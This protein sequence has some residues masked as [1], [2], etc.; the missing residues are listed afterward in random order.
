MSDG[1]DDHD[2]SHDH[3]G[4]GHD[5]HDHSGDDHSHDHDHDHHHHDADDVAVA[6]VTVSSSRDLD[7]DPAGDAIETRLDDHTVA[8]RVVVPDDRAAIGAAIDEG[9]ASADAVV[10][11]G[12]TG[13]TPDDVTVDAARERF[14]M[15]L[16]GFGELFRRRSEADIGDRVMGSRATAGVADRT[17]VFCLPGSENAAAV[18]ADL[19]VPQLPHLV[20]L[21]DR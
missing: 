14:D 18:G 21:A 7:D 8:S 12:G 16:P 11:T 10:T 15:E 4:H 6:V 13:I 9:V 20:G 2:H 1:H 19:L 5:D 3:G 17:P